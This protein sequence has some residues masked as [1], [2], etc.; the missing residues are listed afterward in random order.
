[1]FVKDILPDLSQAIGTCTNDYAF[2]RLTDAVRLLTSNSLISS[3]LGEIAICVCGGFVTLP[4][5]VQTVLGI[6]VD[7]CPAIIRDEWFTYHI[8]GPGDTGYTPFKFTDVL[9]NNY[10]TIRDP[11]EPVKI[12]AKIRA[13]SDQNKILR[14]FGWDADGERIFTTGADGTMEDGFLVPM[15]YGKVLINSDAPAIVKIDRV[16]KENTSDMVD[17]LGIDPDTMEAVSLLGRYRPKE[18][19]PAYTRIRVPAQEVVRVKYRRRVFEVQDE[20]DWIPVNNREALIHA[21]RAVKY[22]LDGKYQNAREAEAEAV[23]LVKQ[24]TDSDRPGGIHPPQIINNELPRAT[25]GSSM[26][27]GNRNY[28][29]SRGWGY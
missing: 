22:R 24:D 12:A 9:G 6:T 28:G 16:Y 3:D 4:P 29:Y 11:A 17:L 15:V 5:E 14:V 27:Y 7:G 13:A 8:N 2:R 10:P 18:N 26:F 1:M 25:A 20:Y 21:I 23:R 19:T